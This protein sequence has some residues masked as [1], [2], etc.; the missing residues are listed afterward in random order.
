M[1]SGRNSTPDPHCQAPQP[2]AGG[3]SHAAGRNPCYRGRFAPSPTG[4]LHFGSLVTAVAS[5]LDARSVGGQWLVRIENLDPPREVPGSADNI[6]RTL[7]AFGFRWDGAVLYQSDRAHFYQEVIN[8]L[9]GARLAYPC[10]CS[11]RELAGSAKPGIDGPV[12]P[13]NCRKG[14]PPDREGRAV[15][16][17]TDDDEI[18]FEDRIQGQCGQRL[19]SEIGDFVILRADGYFAYQLAVVV[20][21]QEQAISDVVRGCDLL[22]S[23]ARQ[24]HLQRTLAYSRPRYAHIP[25]A[26]DAQG[27]KLSKQDAAHPVDGR[28]PL[29]ALRMALEFLNQSQAP[30]EADTLDGIW[31]WAL[32]HWNMALVP[33]RRS[34]S[35]DFQ[36][37]KDPQGRCHP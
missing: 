15:R 33:R 24:I 6:L 23:T 28:N 1:R 20:D 22:H 34:L 10:A 32:R 18:S 30:A 7:E 16:L 29:P 26:L 13:G 31:S 2:L 5:Y 21:D 9:I 11:R 25:L 35:P 12:Y 27:R 14:L 17:L 3:A 8:N 36:V 37:P 4:D 19:E